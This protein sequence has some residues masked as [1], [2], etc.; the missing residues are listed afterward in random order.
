MAKMMTFWFLVLV[1][2]TLNP[3]LHS[4]R[5]KATKAISASRFTFLDRQNDDY[6]TSWSHF[7][8][9]N[10]YSEMNMQYY[11]RFRRQGGLVGG[12]KQ[13]YPFEYARYV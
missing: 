4:G 12:G 10:F 3:T 1:L 2:A 9:T 13:P 7:L 6:E 8:P 5:V 11:R